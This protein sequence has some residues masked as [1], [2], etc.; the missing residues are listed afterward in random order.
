[1]VPTVY[2]LEEARGFFAASKGTCFAHDTATGNRKEISS[3]AE[4]EAFY[5]P[6][7]TQ[8]MQEKTGVKIDPF[9][10]EYRQLTEDELAAM[11][12]IKN[13]ATELWTLID[14]ATANADK[15]MLSLAKTNLE[16]S[17]MWAIKS[18]TA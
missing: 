14:I 7:A 11:V 6:S 2:T 17:V 9:H 4:A 16:Q 1:M 18:L 13:V 8:A 5:K 15:R 12:A 3:L 10:A